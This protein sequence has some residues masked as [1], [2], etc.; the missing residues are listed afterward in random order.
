[1]PGLCIKEYLQKAYVE[2]RHYIEHLESV[3]LYMETVVNF[4]Q[5][6]ACLDIKR[7][8]FDIRR[9]LTSYEYT[10]L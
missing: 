7:F 8:S 5:R 9:L 1:V 2:I 3:P 6:R 4:I 10:V